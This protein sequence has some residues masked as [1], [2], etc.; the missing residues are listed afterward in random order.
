MSYSSLRA[1][2]SAIADAI[3]AKT[4]SSSSIKAEDFPTEISNI[5]TTPEGYHD[6]SEVTATAADVLSPKKIVNAA[7]TV[8]TG[9]I[10][11]EGAGTYSAALNSTTTIPTSGKYF[12][13]NQTVSAVTVEN[14]SAEN[15][16]SGVTVNVKS[17]GTTI[18]TAT[19][20]LRGQVKKLTKTPSS[21]TAVWNKSDSGT[22]TLPYVEF[23]TNE[24]GF[25]PDALICVDSGQVTQQ[26]IWENKSYS[27]AGLNYFVV[28]WWGAFV[29]W[30]NDTVPTGLSSTN[31]KIPVPSNVNRNFYILAIKE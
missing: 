25:V 13:G 11:S 1:L 7:G 24:L 12:T 28:S 2:F 30:Q 20:T 5:I 16:K 8:L 22:L 17:G 19:G 23:N 4:G 27:G 6:T 21:T 10:S 14:L 18:K 26:T 31:Y 3:R 9:N 29:R 15:I